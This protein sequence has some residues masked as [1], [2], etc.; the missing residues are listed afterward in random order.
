[1][2]LGE[3]ID[4]MV[5]LLWQAGVELHLHERKRWHALFHELSRMPG[6]RGKPPVLNGIR[7]QRD[8]TYPWC[9]ALDAYL[10]EL[11]ANRTVTWEKPAF[12]GYTISR[13]TAQ[14]WRE[15][16]TMLTKEENDFFIMH[17]LPRAKQIFALAD[18][19]AAMDYCVQQMRR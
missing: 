6:V 11:C 9:E 4:F 5:L 1:M 2:R 19:S 17:A 18:V 14:R 13:E 3:F 15:A 8:R 7:F 12:S 16:F 10:A